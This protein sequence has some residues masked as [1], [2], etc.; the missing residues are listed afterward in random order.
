[1]IHQQLVRYLAALMLFTLFV[2]NSVLAG[3]DPPVKKTL[4]GSL[5]QLQVDSLVMVEDAKFFNPSYNSILIKPYKVQNKIA[6][7][8]REDA[9]YFLQT[10]FTASV[11]LRIKYTK[12]DNS[13]DSVDKT[14]SIN[15]RPDSLYTNKAVYVLGLSGYR[16]EVKVLSVTDNV[17]WDVWRSLEVVNELQASPL[18]EFSCTGDAIEEIDNEP[19]ASNAEIDELPVSWPNVIVADEYDLEWTFIDSSAIDRYYDGA[20]LNVFRLFD[21][22][23]S[24]VTVTGTSYKIPLLYDNKGRLY[25]RVRPV[26]VKADGSR[27]EANWSSNFLP[28]GLGTFDFDGH[29]RGLNWQATTTFA[30]EGKRKSVIQY[31]D[32]SLRGRQTVTKDNSTGT[33]VV[34]ESFYDYQGRAVVQVLPA[35]TLNTVIK[36]SRNFNIGLNGSEYDKDNFD[37]LL[38]PA[39]YC[40]ASAAAMKSDSGSARYYSSSNPDVNNG[41]NKYIPDAEG[42]PFTEVEYVQ[43]NTG[44]ISRQSGVGPKFKLGSGHETKYFYGT[45]DQSELDALF[46][47][48]AGDKLHYFKTMV[49]DANGQFSVSYTDMHGRTIATALAGQVP[50]SIKLDQLSSYRMDTITETLSDPNTTIVR[51]L[52]ME[53]KKGLLVARPGNHTFNYTLNPESLLK[54]GCD[55]NMVCYDCLYDL[56]ITITDDCNNQKLGGQPFDTTFHNFSIGAI[57]TLCANA[58]QGFSVSFTKFLESGSYDITKKLTVSRYGMDYYRDSLFIWKNTC[59]TKEEFID[60]QRE[61]VMNNLECA[62]SC[63]SCTDSLGT[64]AQ[65]HLR[66]MTQAGILPA[67]SASYREMALT[68]FQSAQEECNQLCNITSEYNDVRNSMLLDM[69]APSGQYANLD[70]LDDVYSVLYTDID[71]TNLPDTVAK[72]R[73]ATNYK[74]ANGNSAL[75]Y[76]EQAGAFVSPSQLS[77]EAFAQKF[78]ASWAEALLP[79]HPEYCKLLKLEELKASMEWN[80]RFESVDNFRDAIAKGY[81]NPT[82]GTTAAFTKYNGFVGSHPDPDPIIYVTSYSYKSPLETGI[83]TV[84]SQGTNVT[85]YSMWAM[86]NVM[87]RCV[88]SNNT[89]TCVNLFATAANVFD[90]TVICDGDLDMAWRNFREMY[91]QLKRGKINGQLVA[92]CP[93][94]PTPATL[95]A[96]YHQ[97]NFGDA[98]ELFTASGNPMPT[99]SSGVSTLYS[100]S[101]TA[102]LSYYDANCRA[103]ASSWWSTIRSCYNASDSAA[104]IN[105]LIQVCKEGADAN[106]PYGASSVKPSS[107]NFYRSFDQVLNAFTHGA[108]PSCNLYMITNPLPYGKQAAGNVK[109]IMTKPD[110]CECNRI[111]EI[112]NKY[113]AVSYLYTSFSDFMKKRYNT[114]ISQADLDQLL[115]LCNSSSTSCNFLVKPILLPPVFQCSSGDVCI[116][117]TQFNTLHYQYVS[118]YP[119]Y[120]PSA[121]PAIDDSNQLRKNKMYEQ[122]MNYKLGFSLTTYDYLK[123]KDSCN[124]FTP[125]CTGGI[126][127]VTF[128]REYNRTPYDTLFVSD[129]QETLDDGGYVVTGHDQ[130]GNS[131]GPDAFIHKFDK[132]GNLEWTRDRGNANDDKLFRTKPTRDGGYITIGTTHLGNISWITPAGDVIVTKL[133]A[134]LNVEWSKVIWDHS[135]LNEYYPPNGADV[136]ELPEEIGGGYAVTAN[137]DYTVLGGSGEDKWQVA[138]LDPSGYIIWQENVA[139][140]NY[141]PNGS[142]Y[143]KPPSM[144]YD[145]GN[146]VLVGSVVLYQAN[147]PRPLFIKLDAGDGSLLESKYYDIPTWA[148]SNRTYLVEDLFKVKD[149]YRF[150]GIIEDY[151]GTNKQHFVVDVDPDGANIGGLTIGPDDINSTALFSTFDEGFIAAQGTGY[152][153]QGFY[154]TK[155]DASNNVVWSHLIPMDGIVKVRRVMQTNDKGIVVLGTKDNGTYFLVRTNKDGIVYCEEE[156]AGLNIEGHEVAVEYLESYVYSNEYAEFDWGG[157]DE[158]GLE[159]NTICE[160]IQEVCGSYSS[161]KGPKLC[162]REAPVFPPVIGDPIDNCSDSTFFAVSVGTELYNAYSDSI[163]NNFDSLY[164]AKCM[165]AYKFET[166]TVTHEASEYHYTLYYYDQAGNLVKTVPPE[167]VDISKFSDAT[168]SGQ[169]ATAKGTNTLLTPDHGLA[170]QYRYNTLNQVVAQKTP[171]AGISQFWYDR[172]GRLVVSQNAQQAIDDKY[173]YTIYDAL[174]RISEVGQKPKDTLMTQVISRNATSLSDWINTGAYKEEI[175]RTVYDVSYFNGDDILN[176]EFLYQRNLRN[177]VSYSQVFDIQPSDGNYVGSHRA[178]T[179]YSYDIH[180]NVDTLLQDYHSGLIDTV[181]NRFKKMVYDY[182]LISGKVNKVAYQPGKPDQFYHKYEYDAENKITAVYTSADHIIWEKEARYQYYKHGPLARTVLGEQ[183]VQGVDYAYTLQGWMKGVNSTSLHTSHD[184]GGDGLASGAN[185]WVG[186][187]AMTFSL[188]YYSTE[189]KSINTSVTPFPAYSSYLGM[190]YKPLYNGNISS[191]TVNIG[192]FNQPMFYNYTYDQLNRITAMDAWTGLDQTNNNWTALAKQTNYKERISYDGNGNILKYLRNGTTVGGGYL[193]MDSL[194]YG[195][196]YS[197][198]KL[199]N[200]RLRH[201]KDAVADGN[202]SIDIDNQADDNYDYDAIGNLIKDTKEGITAISW[203]VY[204]KIRTITK[205]SGTISYT[206]DASGNRIS[207]TAGGK[208]TWYV[209]DASGNVMSTYETGSS[210]I[211]GGDLTQT[212]VHL[213]GSSRLGIFN[214]QRNVESPVS[215]STGIYNFE[216]GSKFFE[217][218]NH[219]GNVLVTITDKKLGVDANTDGNVEFYNADVANANDYYPFG[220]GMPGR[221]YSAGSGYRFGFNGKEKDDEIAKHDYGM[222][223]YDPRL[224]RFLSEDPLTSE[225]PMLTPYQFASNRPID[226]IDLDGL[227]WA[228]DLSIDNN[229]SDGIPVL[230]MNNYVR[231]KVI[232]KSTIVTS[233]ADVQAKAELF[234]A[235]LEKNLQGTDMIWN[236]TFRA[237]VSTTVILDYTPSTGDDGAIGYLVLVDRTS[238][239]TGTT[240]TTVGNTTITTTLSTSTPGDTR[241]EINQFTISLG[242]T[243]DGNIVPDSDLASTSTHEGGHSGGLNH[244]WKLH[245]S[246]HEI[247]DPLENLQPLN[248][249][250]PGTRNTQ[251]I[252]DN[253]MNSD[254][255]PEGSLKNNGVQVLFKQL[256]LL[257]LKVALKSYYEKEDLN[258]PKVNDQGNNGN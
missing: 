169:V 233:Q 8:I 180:G 57:D 55:S 238:T 166:F 209:R 192:Q 206:Y 31:F 235:S 223:I 102:L 20:T 10:A 236:G 116:N 146:L 21:N 218:V 67:D 114:T 137:L 51:D 134:S 86:A 252:K 170:T 108:A 115:L 95:M 176:P 220:M 98:N 210:A 93:S 60:E 70:S 195:Y 81:L 43:D 153:D 41:F 58:A 222:R 109:P 168:W 12:S 187:D 216:R 96:A 133:D 250:N 92:G 32:G 48:E 40:N 224:G 164:R 47:T 66:F 215:N 80:R 6:F 178:A 128:R 148:Y 73:L 35:P 186:K 3:T 44:R 78:E 97:P 165:N 118:L 56:Q 69:T 242:V 91:L 211:N 229:T 175:T 217:L 152:A 179:Y 190:D 99:N 231:V 26:Q 230:K 74:D 79:Y 132:Y 18:Y 204:G 61:L 232:N 30:E 15:Y 202:Y 49:R 255:N 142:Y 239:V 191:M 17:S 240:T 33:I 101:Q 123:F 19:Y 119:S 257:S 214:I 13:V 163:R 167:G 105:A 228:P 120:L 107:S 246:P 157:F 59:K 226:G 208:T 84:Q 197:S 110:A 196:N 90:S 189:Y 161:D 77:P 172:L 162:G 258:K 247:N 100:Q 154:L 54:E 244:P 34:A 249:L 256:Y 198:A 126:E 147:E 106:H 182:D 53:S 181:N 16:V 141:Y 2:N 188:N 38:N 127:E 219:L 36:Y 131:A 145:D 122:F 156:E 11:Q 71:D 177:R 136:I 72:Y 45:P 149:G 158:W 140:N 39:L 184:M 207:K 194:N 129:L 200:N 64:W 143:S 227:E 151:T 113:L 243:M 121:N 42:Y 28:A 159:S 1:M 199:V 144:L 37:K 5:N 27:L 89:T 65:F 174:G 139:S 213:Y 52:V 22:N 201:V 245:L 29:E 203:T 24:R 183:L 234:K 111:N 88:G 150:G 62:P 155:V 75:V 4:D 205:S 85:G 104:I 125:T 248:Q 112:R 253:F 23:A 82:N 225:Y 25:F 254:E 7:Q 103:Y 117:C 221:T 251:L 83:L 138:R 173:S 63:Q 193:D 94:T 160:N 76:D 130:L 171:D 237:K 241:G 87:A 185:Q 135:S 68:A 124:G 14:L 9:N 212:E 50:D 46:G